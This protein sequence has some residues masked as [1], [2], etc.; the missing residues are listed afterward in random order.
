MFTEVFEKAKVNSNVYEVS[1]ETHV[2]DEEHIDEKFVKGQMEMV[3][4]HPIASDHEKKDI[5]EAKKI[6]NDCLEKT[7]QRFQNR[8]TLGCFVSVT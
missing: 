8:E 1:L 5:A 3:S 4:Y 7:L 6:Y 2:G